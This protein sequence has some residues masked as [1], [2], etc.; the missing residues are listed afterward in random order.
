MDVKC[1]LRHYEFFAKIRTDSRLSKTD[2]RRAVGLDR[3]H[4]CDYLRAP[5]PKR[6]AHAM[7]MMNFMIFLA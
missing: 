3:V 1:I 6:P 4:S 2:E 7:M 5:I